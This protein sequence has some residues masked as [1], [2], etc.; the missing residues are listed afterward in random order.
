[1]RVGAPEVLEAWRRAR[2][3]MEGEVGGRLTRGMAQLLEVFAE[4]LRS[5]ASLEGFS[6]EGATRASVAEI[7]AAQYE[8]GRDAVG[9]IEDYATLRRGV[10][11]FVEGRTDLSTL[12]GG[13]VARFFAK[14]LEAADW[15]TERGLAEFEEIVQR[16]MESDLGRA[17]ATDLLTGLPDREMFARKLLPEAVEAHDKLAL[18]VFDLLEFSGT[19][20]A[21]EVPRA[22]E[23][24]LR[25]ADAVREAV[26]EG[27]ICAR[28][29][30]DEVCTLLPEADSEQA[31]R[32]AETVLHGL[33]AGSPEG[34]RVDAGVA[35]YP[36]HGRD[37][38]ELV[39]AALGALSTAKRVG[40]G[41]IVV[42]H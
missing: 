20:G 2:G 41:G 19:V 26:P 40:G 35:G 22:R 17:A 14:L 5:P 11:R 3:G 30:D 24:L 25:L 33:L 10:W 4:F 42:A 13:E 6:R 27:A 21:G 1:M 38:G 15:V 9:V 18:V 7:S 32:T 31:Y 28:F 16:K 8:L 23:S 39:A 29:G 34:L 37:A 36:E 12:D